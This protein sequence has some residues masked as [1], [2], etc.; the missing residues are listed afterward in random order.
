MDLETFVSESILGIM[1]GVHNAQ[2]QSHMRGLNLGR[3]YPRL[4]T[5]LITKGEM[6]P[7][8]QQ[9]YEWSVDPEMAKN[10][11]M[12]VTKDGDA[13]DLISFDIAV[14]V[15]SSEKSETGQETSGKG[16]ASIKVLE[17]GI[18][19]KRTESSG[20]SSAHAHETRIKFR[21]PVCFSKTG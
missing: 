4:K 19:S 3:V 11:Q 6:P 13:A 9:D 14:T 12:L 7:G 2:T 21:I 1:R 20:E 17:V 15:Q 10:A 5:V 8:M 16:G 18:N